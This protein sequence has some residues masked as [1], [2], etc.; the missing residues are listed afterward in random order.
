LQPVVG[1]AVVMP[2]VAG[3][4]LGDYPRFLYP[5]MSVLCLSGY[6]E[7][8]SFAG[9]GS[10][11][12][13]RVLPKPFSEQTLLLAVNELLRWREQEST[14]VPRRAWESVPGLVPPW[15]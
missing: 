1:A 7:A 5:R 12:G 6:G 10:Q 2:G 4:Q 9:V 8:V 15:V 14:V 3:D 11:V 13:A